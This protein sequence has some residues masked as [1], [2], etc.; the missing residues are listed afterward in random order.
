MAAP[1]SLWLL[2]VAL[3]P[4]SCAAWALGHLKQPAPLPLVI[5]HGMG[6]AWCKENIG[7]IP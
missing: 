3:L 7:M 5:W 2:A 1:S 6:N 4:W